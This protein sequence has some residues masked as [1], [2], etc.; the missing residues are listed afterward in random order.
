[1]AIE[2]TAELEGVFDSL[3]AVREAVFDA[4]ADEAGDRTAVLGAEIAADG[5][6]AEGQRQAGVLLPPDAEVDDQ[7]QAELGIGEL[8]LVDEEAGVDAAG[9]D[10]VGNLVEHHD[11]RDERVLAEQ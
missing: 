3:R 1:M 4:G 9:G 7:V 6:S 8:A 5:V 11:L 2:A 10:L